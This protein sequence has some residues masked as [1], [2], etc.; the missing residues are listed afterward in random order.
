METTLTNWDYWALAAKFAAYLGCFSSSGSSLYLLATPRLE[1]ELK[2]KLYRIILIMAFVG[3]AGSIAQIAVQ[4]GRLLDDG[5]DGMMDVEMLALVNDGPLGTS[6]LLRLVG[7]VALAVFA[8][9]SI[10]SGWF[11]GIGALLTATSFSFV[12]HGTE[13]PRVL[14]TG[15]ITLHLL[16]VS[17]WIGALWPLRQCLSHSRNLSDAGALAHR[18]GQQAIWVVGGLAVAG[19]ILAY[20]LAGSVQALFSSQYGLTLLVKFAAVTALLALAAANKLRFVPALHQG[21]SAAARHLRQSI[22]WEMAAVAF[23]LIVTAVL[24][25]VTPL[26]ELMETANG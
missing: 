10:G 3:A 13:D 23:V 15:L 16:G 1:V 19:S 14:M 12:G 11:G 18:F 8:F 5:M 6:V 9:Q 20:L 7:L 4:A 17:F 22:S 2:A 26:P 24:T 25:T 21:D